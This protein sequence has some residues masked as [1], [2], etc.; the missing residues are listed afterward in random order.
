MY[1]V[2]KICNQTLFETAELNR[3]FAFAISIQNKSSYPVV[4]RPDFRGQRL[5][6]YFDDVIEGS[7]AAT[8]SDID[9]MLSFASPWLKCARSDPAR[10]SIIIHCGAGISRSAAAALLLLTLYFCNYLAAAAHLFRTH[11]QVSP[12]ALVSGLIFQ[13]LGSDFGTD[14]FAAIATAKACIEL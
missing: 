1:P 2:V 12:N 11:P 8:P 5:D 4:L 13:K 6:L 10:A 7:G 3:E 14:I 9:A